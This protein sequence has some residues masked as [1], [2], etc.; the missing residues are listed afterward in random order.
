MSFQGYP[1][2]RA[3][4]KIEIKYSN[5]AKD[6]FLIDSVLFDFNISRPLNAARY[7]DGHMEY[8]PSESDIDFKCSGYL[9]EPKTKKE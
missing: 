6:S 4:I 7:A 9:I 8:L 1:P 5:G 2:G 3:T